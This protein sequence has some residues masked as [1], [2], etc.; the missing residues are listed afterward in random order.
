VHVLCLYS[1][2]SFFSIMARE[3]GRAGPIQRPGQLGP[4]P[5]FRLVSKTSQPEPSRAHLQ[6]AKCWLAPSPARAGSCPALHLMDLWCFSLS[7]VCCKWSGHPRRVCWPLLPNRTS[8]SP[9][10]LWFYSMAMDGQDFLDQVW[11]VYCC[12][13]HSFAE[14]WLMWSSITLLCDG[15]A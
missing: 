13:A 2:C 6:R 10:L 9:P 5:I 12:D 3:P 14:Y 8:S 7:L 1:F 11:P 15:F 4:S